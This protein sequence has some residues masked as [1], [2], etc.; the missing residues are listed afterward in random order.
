MQTIETND[1]SGPDHS[2][3]SGD[4]TTTGTDKE[5]QVFRKWEWILFFAFSMLKVKYDAL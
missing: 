4:V 3:K 5:Y 2:D 1:A